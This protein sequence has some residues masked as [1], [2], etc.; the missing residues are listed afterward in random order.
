MLKW[1]TNCTDYAFRT[2][3]HCLDLQNASARPGVVTEVV[4]K[5]RPVTHTSEPSEFE[6]QV[7][8]GKRV[9]GEISFDIIVPKE[10]ISDR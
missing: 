5:S 10:G 4:W 1:V 6:D 9:F 7:G 3:Q 2:L 8:V